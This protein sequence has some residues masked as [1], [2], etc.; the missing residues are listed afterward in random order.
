MYSIRVSV[1]LQAKKSMSIKNPF[2]LFK[3]WYGEA[4]RLE[5]NDPNAM[6]LATTG[7]GLMPS[8]RIV[9]LK[10]F[11]P[12]GFVFFTNYTS[13]KGREIAQNPQ[14]ALCLH[15]KSL[16]RQIRIEGSVRKVSRSDS[17]AYFKTRPRDSQIGAHASIQSSL[18][19]DLS[20]FKARI[21]HFTALYEGKEVPCPEFWGGYLVKP[22]KIEF[23]EEKPFR[24]HERSVYDIEYH[25]DCDYTY[26]TRRLYP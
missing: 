17:E 25:S 8:V 18:M 24:L 5:P 19:G 1:N 7:E 22:Q 16:K 21:D 2:D 9:L 14:T 15:W 6:S 13:Q 11:G 12:E 10:E 26:K 20:E 23:W 3:I 4:C